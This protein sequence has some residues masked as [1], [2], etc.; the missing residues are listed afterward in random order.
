MDSFKLKENV[1]Y[2]EEAILYMEAKVC[3]YLKRLVIEACLTVSGSYTSRL[4]S[5]SYQHL[6]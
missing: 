2:P 5:L 1:F 3:T 6:L 4:W